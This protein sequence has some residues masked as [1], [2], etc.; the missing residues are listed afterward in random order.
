MD[1]SLHRNLFPDYESSP[2]SSRP[3]Q[4]ECD[5]PK[6]SYADESEYEFAEEEVYMTVDSD[7]SNYNTCAAT[8][9]GTT[10]I[11]NKVVNEQSSNN[12]ALAVSTCNADCQKQK[13]DNDAFVNS[14]FLKS[15][16]KIEFENSHHSA[17]PNIIN[18]SFQNS[19][20][21]IVSGDYPEIAADLDMPKTYQEEETV[22][23]LKSS[24]CLSG[25]EVNI[26]CVSTQVKASDVDIVSRDCL[27]IETELCE[28]SKKI[29][30]VKQKT[31]KSSGCNSNNSSV[32]LK[33]EPNFN[34][35]KQSSF[36]IEKGVGSSFEN[37]NANVVEANY[38]K[39]EP[40]PELLVLKDYQ[41]I[42][43][44]S[45]KEAN[46]VISNND[47]V[48]QKHESNFHFNV[49][50]LFSKAN[51]KNVE[52]SSCNLTKDKS[53][54]TTN[55]DVLSRNDPKIEPVVCMDY[56][57][58][59]EQSVKE[60]VIGLSN[61]DT[62]CQK[63]NADSGLYANSVFIKTNKKKDEGS[64]C[65]LAEE[66]SFETISTNVLSK[67][68][69]DA[70]M[71]HEKKEE[72]SGKETVVGLSNSDLVCQN[73][74]PDSGLNTSSSFSTV[75][76]KSNKERQMLSNHENLNKEIREQKQVSCNNYSSNDNDFKKSSPVDLKPDFFSNHEKVLSSVDN[77]CTKNKEI[78]VCFC[79]LVYV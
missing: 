13:S 29:N 27:K 79:F 26:D 49:D 71:N 6:T 70:C 60:A 21:E 78:L 64:S 75:D 10:S 19:N 69:P 55:M 50:S 38:L 62:I 3:Q 17:T 59:C 31:E 48:C 18:P 7:D 30:S 40:K 34:S 52:G 16:D 23:A 45:L 24:Y 58:T 35:N 43:E 57:N 28:I 72:Q 68:E 66:K 67:I 1:P 53:I 9:N 4:S 20:G 15:N 56:E 54:K 74:A 42:S 11:A 36:A 12:V 33:Q 44:Q 77:D 47:I 63:D 8:S 61:A 32:F 76:D 39:V 2:S 41:E 14:H 22:S 5:S 65:S 37:V 51:E 46:F 73:Q 25:G